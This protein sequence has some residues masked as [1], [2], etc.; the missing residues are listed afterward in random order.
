[1]RHANCDNETPEYIVLINFAKLIVLMNCLYN[2][3]RNNNQKLTNNEK[4]IFIIL[5]VCFFVCVL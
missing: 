1:M 4:N 3:Q 5:V 2:N